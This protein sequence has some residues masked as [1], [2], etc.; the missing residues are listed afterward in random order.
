MYTS[1]QRRLARDLL[2]HY[3]DDPNR[4]TQHA[5]VRD[6]LQISQRSYGA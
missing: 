5:H 3:R 4:W 2:M 6:G 1:E